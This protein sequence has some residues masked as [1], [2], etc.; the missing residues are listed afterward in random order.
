M[1]FRSMNEQKL[2]MRAVG[3]DHKNAVP[4]TTERPSRIC[5]VFD[6]VDSA[7]DAE[8]LIRQAA[9][10]YECERQTFRFDKMDR[11][12]VIWKLVFFPQRRCDADQLNPGCENLELEDMICGLFD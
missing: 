7:F 10:A 8:V 3:T 11:P 6:D 4:R 2:C 12:A 1:N 5:V 9:S